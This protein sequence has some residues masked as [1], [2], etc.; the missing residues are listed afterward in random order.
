[1]RTR[2]ATWTTTGLLVA[3]LTTACSPRCP[4]LDGE[5]P[6]GDSETPLVE[7]TGQDE[8]TD[9]DADGF[10]VED[11][12][13]DD[14]DPTVNPNATEACN[15]VDDDCDGAVD[16]ESCAEGCDLWV[17]HDHEHVQDAIDAAPDGASV[18]LDAGSW[19][20]NVTIQDR[21]LE[22]RGLHGSTATVIDG[23]GLGSTVAI[24]GDASHRVVLNALSLRHGQANT[25]GALLVT[26][27]TLEASDLQLL[28]SNA[29]KG[30]G[31]A[32]LGGAEVLAS[33]LR[34]LDNVATSDG[35][36]VLV[37]E[38]SSLELSDSVLSGNEAQAG[39]GAGFLVT[40]AAS[41]LV[42]GATI[43][44]NNATESN[45]QRG[46]G[47][48]VE[49]AFVELRD[50]S[51]V[52]NG[53]SEAGGALWIGGASTLLIEA[54]ELSHGSA[55]SAY[56]D[57]DGSGGLD[58]EGE[59][60]LELYDV[61]FSSNEA[62]C[63]A[64]GAIRLDDSA[65]LSGEDLQISDNRGE[66][67]GAVAIH[68][69]ATF[70]AQGIQLVD[71]AGSYAGAAYLYGGSM[72]LSDATL[73]NNSSDQGGGALALDMYA[74]VS[75]ERAL[76]AGNRASG[77]G[78]FAALQGGAALSLDNA[79]VAGNRC[80]EDGGGVMV[81]GRSS[82]VERL[83][84]SQ[85][86]F[87]GNEAGE[88]GGGIHTDS[89]GLS[90]IELSMVNTVIHG[91]RAA[92]GGGLFSVGELVLEVSFSDI[93]GNDPEDW[94]G[95]EDPVGDDGKLAVDPGF[96]STA[97]DDWSAWDLHLT[98]A[99]PLVDAG[100]PTLLDPDGGPSDLGAYGGA[101][102]G[103]WDLDG[104][105]Y[106]GWWQPGPYDSKSYPSEGWD[107]DDSDAAIYPGAGC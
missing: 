5:S 48:A 11:G 76:I 43:Q 65:T 64:P 53:A 2:R 106:P 98:T 62:E 81:R 88:D 35:G 104:D 73:T 63:W 97:G 74:E 36:G 60:S 37:D 3:V 102:G 55:G 18:C 84:L 51:I 44:D 101:P 77:G 1:M 49:D 15:G 54:T 12:D 89:G 78:G 13:C 103:S 66:S 61:V 94:I 80:D 4:S 26:G 9:A 32:V 100:E 69:Q 31:L 28:E 21:S 72:V 105:G 57:C 42:Q 22:I 23:Q 83:V 67:G 86:V 30:A 14:G 87:V 79:I 56:R 50:S 6:L 95:V 20:E 29:T 27:C 82:T 39:D 41:L 107:C 33:E 91:N 71:N 34:V 52:E 47:L 16:E 25:G 8:P 46:G 10:S 19:F 70:N 93:Q 38:A 17:P 85:T 75:L 59:T 7:D 92:S 24:S 99:S 96:L 45:G 40:G 58:A 90:T 68:D